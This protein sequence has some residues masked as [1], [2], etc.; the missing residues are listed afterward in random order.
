MRNGEGSHDWR[1]E[2]FRFGL[3]LSDHVGT[4][5]FHEA[6][7]LEAQQVGRLDLVSGPAQGCLIGGGGSRDLQIDISPCRL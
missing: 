3:L 4:L 7:A 6:G 1:R 5:Q 2:S